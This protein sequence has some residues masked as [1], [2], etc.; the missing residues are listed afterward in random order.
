MFFWKFIY[1]NLDIITYR[2]YM[3]ARI[4]SM[5]ILKLAATGYLPGFCLLVFCF[6]GGRGKKSGKKSGKKK[7]VDTGRKREEKKD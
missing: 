7:K 1:C 3:A 6:G 4:D 2:F 5:V